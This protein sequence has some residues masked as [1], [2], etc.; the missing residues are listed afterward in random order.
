ERVKNRGHF[1]TYLIEGQIH[2]KAKPAPASRTRN[3]AV[4]VMIRDSQPR[5]S[6]SDTR[7]ATAL[8]EETMRLMTHLPRARPFRRPPLGARV[9][10]RIEEL[11]SR[12]VPYSVSGNA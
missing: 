12:V 10:P 11:E 3:H 5:C 8:K 6:G 2:G 7:P 9:F 1:R 4:P